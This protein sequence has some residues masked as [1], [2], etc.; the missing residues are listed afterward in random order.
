M[1]T[2][3]RRIDLAL[4]GPQS[5]A[6]SALEPRKTIALP[7]GRGVG[8]SWFIRTIAFLLVAQWRG[9]VR[10][11]A[12]KPFK[13]IR[14]VV[15]MP[16]LKQFKDVHGLAIERENDEDWVHLGG[17]LDRTTWQIRFP[18]GSWI[19]PFPA[20]MHNSKRARGLRCDVVLTDETDDIDRDVFES[21][22]RPWFS[23]PWSLKIRL[24]G[25]T[26]TR[27]RH[28]LLYHLHRLGLS[29]DDTAERYRT[30]HA[31]YKDAPET[32]DVE[33]VED[34]RVNSPKETFE[35]EWECN[36][37]AG[38]GLVYPFDEQFHVRQ[39]P[40]LSLFREFHVG[41]DHGWVDP[42]ALLLAGVMGH[43]ND[44]TLWLLDEWY[45]RECPNHV[46]NDRAKTW[47][48]ATFWPDPSRPDRISDL[49]EAGLN[50]GE[51][52]NNIAGGIA[53]VADL[54][55]IRE[56]PDGERYARFYVSPKCRET[57]REFGLYRRKKRPD[58]TFDDEPEDKNNH[59][60][61]GGTPVL[62][63]RGEVPIESITTADS[64]LTRAGWRSVLWSGQ[65]FQ[66]APVWNLETTQ[67]TIIGT[68]D[69]PVWTSN[70]GWVRL[71]ALGYGDILCAW[72]STE[73]RLGSD[74]TENCSG[75]IRPHQTRT[76]ETT[77]GHSS[78]DTCTGRY[79][80]TTRA[81]SLTDSIFTTRTKIRSTTISAILSASLALITCQSTASAERRNRN[82]GNESTSTELEC[83]P[84]SGTGVQQAGHGIRSTQPRASKSGNRWTLSAISAAPHSKLSAD[85]RPTGSAPI[86]AN[87][88]GAEQAA[89]ITRTEPAAC[90]AQCSSSVDTSKLRLVR[91]YVLS[92]K[93][94]ERSA[95]V[96][97][98]TVENDH[99]FFANG[100]LV[101]NS[102]DSLRYLAVGRFGRGLNERF[103][104][105]GR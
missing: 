95:P 99:E 34:A 38:E 25:G 44:A 73:S 53:R 47:S 81:Q 12:L 64:V 19:Q 36:F 32:V 87:Q 20:E 28:G 102:M 66:S 9:R 82:S 88:A 31:T 83:S 77:S 22:A 5:R 55:F 6:Y 16:T 75:G 7:W 63:A 79:G 101:H 49:R 67:G 86:T 100:V 29:K 96:Y 56:L 48:T 93:P 35:R 90:A 13:G 91:A 61:V 2:A 69:H 46:W 72:E 4:N 10:S 57:I 45:E 27:G 30:F 51:T 43:G 92:S 97:D 76:F 52:D 84:R 103:V 26:P 62:T 60:L 59:C 78:A 41:M 18:D 23:E 71:D 21:V 74:S 11:D 70:R 8:K 105:S 85:A 17:K 14:I 104:T 15:L 68:P 24:C 65:T 58:G 80:S 37:D 98:L 50:V 39:P 33:E 54:L 94:A 3:V 1:A 42:G 40:P 89:S